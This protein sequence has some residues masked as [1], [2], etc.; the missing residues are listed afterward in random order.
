M[1]ARQPHKLEV[2]G[3]NPAPATQVFDMAAVA[4]ITQ[5]HVEIGR[6]KGD[7]SKKPCAGG[8]KSCLLPNLCWERKFKP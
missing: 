3:S 5:R 8:I 7:S 1:V 4:E 2:A 6:I